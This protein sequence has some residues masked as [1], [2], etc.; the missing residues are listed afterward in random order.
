[1]L[2]NAQVADTGHRLSVGAEQIV[3][4]EQIVWQ[5]PN[6]PERQQTRTRVTLSD[7][8]VYEFFCSLSA[9]EEAVGVKQVV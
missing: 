1:M 6:D 2:V 4:A 7:G 3:K 9:F 5:D 8:S